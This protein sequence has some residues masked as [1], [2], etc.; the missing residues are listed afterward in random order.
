MFIQVQLS[1]LLSSLSEKAT[2]VLVLNRFDELP[3]FIENIGVVAD[4]KLAMVGN[5]SR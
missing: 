1:E 3:D 5:R 4:C 2:L